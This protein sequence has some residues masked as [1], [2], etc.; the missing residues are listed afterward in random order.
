MYIEV[1][2]RVRVQVYRLALKHTHW[3][4]MS[5]AEDWPSS[6]LTAV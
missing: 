3:T 2:V 6:T 1:R 4:C 5:E